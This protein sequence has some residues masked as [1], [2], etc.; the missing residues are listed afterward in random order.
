MFL[1]SSHIIGPWPNNN[2]RNLNTKFPPESVINLDATYQT[3]FD[4]T[5]RWQF[6]QS[7]SHRAWENTK[8]AMPS[9]NF[10]PKRNATN[11]MFPDQFTD[12]VLLIFGGVGWVLHIE[13]C[14]V[15]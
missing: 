13:E 10:G 15:F 14:P 2:R 1:D 8:F 6:Y 7:S 4:K 3:E 12:P 5:L 9:R 11:G